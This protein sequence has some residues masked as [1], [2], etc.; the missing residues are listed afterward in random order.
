MSPNSND[1]LGLQSSYSLV[2]RAHSGQPIH[3]PP[4]LT[5]NARG[6]EK[7]GFSGSMK[8]VRVNEKAVNDERLVALARKLLCMNLSDDVVLIDKTESIAYHKQMLDPS[9]CGIILRK[10]Y[11]TT[12][13]EREAH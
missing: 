2:T 1:E 10:D 12:S 11:G 13:Q 7:P 4:V 8:A 9:I 6:R 5:R 3:G